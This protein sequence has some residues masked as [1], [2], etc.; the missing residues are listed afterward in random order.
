[1]IALPH[2]FKIHP[3]VPP[4]STPRAL[5]QI[6]FSHNL[7]IPLAVA[8]IVILIILL[9]LRVICVLP[10]HWWLGLLL[11]KD[12]REIFNMRTLARA[13]QTKT[14]QELVS[15]HKCWFGRA[16]KKKKSFTPAASRSQIP[17][18]RTTIQC[19]T[20]P[21]TN[22]G[23]VHSKQ[24][25]LADPRQTTDRCAL[26]IKDK[27]SRCCS[28]ARNWKFKEFLGTDGE[29]CLRELDAIILLRLNSLLPARSHWWQPRKEIRSRMPFLRL[30]AWVVFPFC[31]FQ[32]LPILC[33][34]YWMRP[35]CRFSWKIQLHLS[36]SLSL[37]LCNIKNLRPFRQLPFVWGRCFFSVCLFVCFCFVLFFFRFW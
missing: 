17:A 34:D 36:L 11:S 26:P 32:G 15:P 13:V 1:M 7:L 29:N 10:Y 23:H 31:L 4:L 14:R 30:F 12:G 37:S 27:A 16:K 3:R 19:V 22:S 24:Q 6:L 9:P 18:T 21:A 28:V 25:S 20:Q 8:T 35:L 2:S 33:N 5:P